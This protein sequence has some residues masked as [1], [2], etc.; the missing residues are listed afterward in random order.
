MVSNLKS[1]NLMF[2]I[3]LLVLVSSPVQAYP[4]RDAYMLRGGPMIVSGDEGGS[5]AVVGLVKSPQYPFGLWTAVFVG[6]YGKKN[7]VLQGDLIAAYGLGEFNFFL[8][9]GMRGSK[10]KY[11]S[12]QITYGLLVGPTSM[13]LRRYDGPKGTVTEGVIALT[14]PF[15]R[16]GG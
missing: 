2:F 7:L 4:I 10:S 16:F 8:G 6:G 9:M 15:F 14:V 1:K 11:S 12:G 3:L 5:G 13:A